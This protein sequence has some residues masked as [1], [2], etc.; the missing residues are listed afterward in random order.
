MYTSARLPRAATVFQGALVLIGEHAYPTSLALGIPWALLDGPDAVTA[1][2]LRHSS[3]N[4]DAGVH[5]IHWHE[6]LLAFSLHTRRMGDEE[7]RW[8]RN[9]SERVA[10]KAD[11]EP[12]TLQGRLSE[13]VAWAPLRVAQLSPMLVSAGR[14]IA[15]SGRIIARPSFFLS[16][17]PTV[18]GLHRLADHAALSLYIQRDSS[19]PPLPLPPALPPLRSARLVRRGADFSKYSYG[20]PARTFLLGTY[21]ASSPDSPR[22]RLD[23]VTVFAGV[24]RA[25]SLSESTL[26]VLSFRAF[27]VHGHDHGHTTLPGM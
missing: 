27:G 18:V 6:S 16:S 2:T 26:R 24:G 12:L 22:P 13:V 19:R 7:G 8:S 11:D 23:A 17:S 9:N 10:S 14:S 5:G 1:V 25:T 20:S 3:L 15:F 21:A 4:L